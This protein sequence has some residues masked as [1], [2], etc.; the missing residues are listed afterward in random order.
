MKQLEASPFEIGIYTLGDIVADPFTKKAVSAKTRIQEIIEAAKLADEA[1]LDIFGIGEHHR[2]DYAVSSPQMVLSAIAQSTK[3]IKLTSTTT[4][5]NTTDPV[6]LFEDFATLDLISNGRAE[7]TAGRGAFVESFPLFGYSFDDYDAL[8]EEHLQLLLELNKN[9][10]VTWSGKFRSPL[11]QSEIAPRPEQE[12]L[13]IWVGVGGTPSS[14]ERAGRYGL[15]LTIAMIGGTHPRFLP[16]I[17][18]Y[19]EGAVRAGVSQEQLQV[20]VTG[21]GFIAKS[22]QEAKDTFYPYYA[23]YME[24]MNRSRGIHASMPRDAFEIMTR[25]ESVM[26][27]GSPQEIIEKVLIQHELYGHNRFM[28]QMDIGGMPYK[29]LARSIELLATEVAPVLRREIGK[30]VQKKV[31]G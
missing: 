23:N 25:P 28:M 21:H 29:E 6:R 7:I 22:M 11:H 4:V 30:K 8:F 13:P 24:Y 18:A 1:G 19:H 2:L 12:S 20:G 31:L 5:L 9:E 16:L 10:R 3:Q 26:F 17:D 15:G 14:A 27:I